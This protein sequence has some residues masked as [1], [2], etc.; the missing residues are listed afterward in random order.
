MN[1]YTREDATR[2][3]ELKES[4]KY[5]LGLAD[6]QLYRLGK[7]VIKAMNDNNKGR[8]LSLVDIESGIAE[9]YEAYSMLQ[10]K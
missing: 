6:K 4:N 5:Y 1:T 10:N 8:T 9:L 7:L 3:I 2:N